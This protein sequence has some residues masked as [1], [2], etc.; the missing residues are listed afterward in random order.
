MSGI[1]LGGFIT[2]HCFRRLPGFGN[3]AVLRGHGHSGGFVARRPTQYNSF[4]QI[5]ENMDAAR[6]AST[7]CGTIPHTTVQSGISQEGS[8]P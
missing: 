5:S 6:R 8:L 2:S 7:Y 3:F 1:I 4:D